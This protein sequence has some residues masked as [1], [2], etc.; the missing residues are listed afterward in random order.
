MDSADVDLSNHAEQPTA[1]DLVHDVVTQTDVQVDGTTDDATS[2]PAGEEPPEF[3]SAAAASPSHRE[4][5]GGDGRHEPTETGS[6]VQTSTFNDVLRR[7][8]SHLEERHYPEEL[9]ES[10]LAT[11]EHDASGFAVVVTWQSACPHAD[12]NL[13]MPEHSVRHDMPHQRECT[14]RD[15]IEWCITASLDSDCWINLYH[16]HRDVQVTVD[17][18]NLSN[19]TAA[20]TTTNIGHRA[21]EGREFQIRRRSPSW[22]QVRLAGTAE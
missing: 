15:R 8:R 18:I 13:E 10:L 4:N 22:R 5:I 14:N 2:E 9:G 21:D 20:N 17:L 3:G 12:V 19:G 6:E 7:I 11:A 1:S 16:T